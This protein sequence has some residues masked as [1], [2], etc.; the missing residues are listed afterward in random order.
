[1]DG[2]DV[3]DALDPR[4][5][6]IDRIEDAAQKQRRKPDQ[7]R[8]TSCPIAGAPER[9]E[10]GM[11]K[12]DGQAAAT[13]P[14]RRHPRWATSQP[15]SATSWSSSSSLVST[16]GSRSNVQSWVTDVAPTTPK[17]TTA[18]SRPSTTTAAVTS[19]EAMSASSAGAP[20]VCASCSTRNASRAM[21]RNESG[22]NPGS[23]FVTDVRSRPGTA[24][25]PRSWNS[26]SRSLTI[27][28][29][30]ESRCCSSASR[31]AR[32][33][34][35]PVTCRNPEPR[36]STGEWSGSASLIEVPL[37]GWFEARIYSGPLPDEVAVAGL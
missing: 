18:R 5:Q 17:R 31:L 7:T 13:I 29:S 22:V 32:R 10:Q 19:A 28:A 37:D 8:D 1:M 26:R 35:I 20:S 6:G 15:P 30:S 2:E 11:V 14:V 4:G 9:G 27:V 21:S 3:H 34:P 33:L 12:L 36:D 23:T 24:S 25:S 16:D